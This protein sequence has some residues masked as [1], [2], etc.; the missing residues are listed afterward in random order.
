VKVWI[1]GGLGWKGVSMGGW[2]KGDGERGGWGVGYRGVSTLW[3][4]RSS[5]VR[6]GSL[7]VEG[8]V[9][10]GSSLGGRGRGRGRVGLGGKCLVGR[11]GGVMHRKNVKSMTKF[12]RSNGNNRD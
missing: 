4:G 10:V 2:M 8:R 7:G 12:F 9:I 5:S 6:G 1:G 3:G 11:R